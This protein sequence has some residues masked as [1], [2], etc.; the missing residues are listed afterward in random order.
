MLN[1]IVR[2]TLAIALSI[3]VV[4]EFVIA[5]CDSDIRSS[6]HH[7][8]APTVQIVNK[9]VRLTLAIALSIEVVIEIVIAFVI[10]TFDQVH[11][12]IGS[13]S[14]F[15]PHTLCVYTHKSTLVYIYIYMWYI[16]EMLAPRKRFMHESFNS[17]SL[18]EQKDSCMNLL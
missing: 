15:V 9:I 1:K 14:E 10:Q 13:T 5:F 18:Q 2:L 4:I 16:P 17:F 8:I 12:T 6:P 3:E 11:I 7:L